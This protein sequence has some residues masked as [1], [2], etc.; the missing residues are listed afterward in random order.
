MSAILQVDSGRTQEYIQKLAQDAVA[1]I[2]KL[3]PTRS[4]ELLG[5]FVS[6]MFRSVVE[7]DR[8]AERRQ[9]QAEGIA[10]AKAKGTRFGRPAK[11]LPENFYEIRQAWR[12][13]KLVLRDAADA[14]GMPQS[15][16][17]DKAIA[18]ERTVGIT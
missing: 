15:T 3:D 1:E 5:M 8:C 6:E 9:K 10:T 12:E 4:K 17:Y 13:G 16:F 7:Q 11:P 14:C 2:S 18:Y